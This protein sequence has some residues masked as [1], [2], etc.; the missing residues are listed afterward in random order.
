MSLPTGFMTGANALASHYGEIPIRRVSGPHHDLRQLGISLT[1]ASE[2]DSIVDIRDF[3]PRSRTRE[4]AKRIYLVVQ[5]LNRAQQQGETTIPAGR[6]LLDNTHIIEEAIAAILRDLPPRFYRQ[7]HLSKSESD[8][9]RTLAIAWAYIADTD[10]AISARGFQEIVQGFQDIQPLNIGE[11]WALPSLLRF[12]LVENLRRLAILV[13]QVRDMRLI[14]NQA[15]DQLTASLPGKEAAILSSYASYAHD[16]TFATQFLHRVRDGSRTSHAALTWLETALEAAGT[17]AEQITL[18]EHATLSTSTLTINNIIRSLR[19]LDDIDWAVWFEEVSHI[20]ALLRT[21][22]SFAALDFSSR[23]IYRTA[24]ETL[25]ARSGKR[26]CEVALLAVEMAEAAAKDT[27]DDRQTIDIGSLLIGW[28]RR[29]LERAINYSPAFGERLRGWVRRSGWLGIALPVTL[30]T[31]LFITGLVCILVSTGFDTGIIILLAALFLAPALE[32]SVGLYNSLTSLLVEP[33]KLIGYEYKEGV[34]ADAATFVVIPMLIAT[35][36]DIEQAIRDLEVHYLANM[37]GEL[38]FALLSDWPDSDKEETAADCDLLDFAREQMAELNKRYPNKGPDRFYLLHRR[39]LYN[40]AEGCWMG[41]ERKRGKLQEFNALLRGDRD[42]TFLVPAGSLPP[43]IQYVMTL[44]TDTR[45]MRDTVA[46][47]VGKLAHPLNRPV[48]D[49][50]E[51]RPSSGY[52]ILQP[53][54]TPS[55]TADDQASFFQRIFSVNRGIDP[56]VFTVS[57]VYQDLFGEGIFTGKGLYHID[58]MET[59]L[60]GGR[61]PENAVLS[62]DLLESAYART[63]LVTDVEVFEDYPTRYLADAARHHRWTRGDW[64]LLP[65]ILNPRSDIPGLSRWMMID[66]LRRSLTP[67]LWTGASIAGWS[68]LPLDSAILWQLLLIATL[69]LPLITGLISTFLPR[70]NS[71][72]TLSSYFASFVQDVSSA[73]LQAITKV[74]LIVHDAW[75]MGD[76]IARALYRL[77]IS[78]RHLSNGTLHH[79]MPDQTGMAFSSI[80]SRWRAC[81]RLLQS[82]SRSRLLLAPAHCRSRYS[83][84]PSGACHPRSPG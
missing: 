27:A 23:D 37:S 29:E 78:R 4:N 3:N 35:R 49:E 6:W 1:Q 44:D 59:A 32:A 72:A 55:M 30:L 33:A 54:V 12:V 10:S 77:L 80:M 66:N 42:T 64:Q 65:W 16:K 31:A 69:F 43:N 2:T 20:D 84:P 22:T 7:L 70:R 26:E 28:R 13:A 76:A 34:P 40:E 79:T 21:R 45:T 14:A 56:Y 58:A 61:I 50:T 41:W 25:A 5:T 82:A 51:G 83:S 75:L 60:G 8:V 67:I 19:L 73:S 38:Y 46:R 71:R 74:V 53:S 15:A 9:P 47:L 57:N 36:D 63:A 52:S 62:H 68:L 48:F 39:R 81:Y 17:D 18:D 11:L 24:I